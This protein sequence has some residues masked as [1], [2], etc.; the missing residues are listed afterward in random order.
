MPLGHPANVVLGAGKNANDRCINRWVFLRNLAAM[1]E[2]G[3]IGCN[4]DSRSKQTSEVKGW[5]KVP[6]EDNL[7]QK[8]L[9]AI[10]R[11][12]PYPKNRENFINCGLH[13]TEHCFKRDLKYEF[14]KRGKQKFILMDDVVPSV[15]KFSA[16]PRKRRSSESRAKTRKNKRIVQ[17]VMTA[18]APFL[19]SEDV[20]EHG[21]LQST[22][23]YTD[24]TPGPGTSRSYDE[25]YLFKSPTSSD[26]N[27]E[28][29]TGKGN[30]GD[31]FVDIISNK[32]VIVDIEKLKTLFVRCFNCGKSSTVTKVST[33]G[34]MVTFELEC[35]NE[36]CDL[37]TWNSQF[38][39]QRVC[40]GNL[41]L[42]AGIILSGSTFEP[43]RKIMQT[44]GVQFLGKSSFYKIQ[45]KFIFPA[46][47]HVYNE[48]RVKI[49]E[50]AKS[51]SVK[52]IGDGRFDSPGNSAT[53]GTYTLMNS[54]NNE[55][56]DFFIA[57]VRNAGNS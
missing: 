29:E 20:I 37:T 10:K 22:I 39:Q 27:E 6:T 17:G 18:S 44:A 15:F 9:V 8:W 52:L 14:T 30:V 13:F 32:Y 2:S 49:L 28:E 34:T 21:Q 33:K 45:E 54:E 25:E 19:P 53:F 16:Q 4:N 43:I 7:R 50:K 36:E 31:P 51:G 47:N 55:I 56:F 48:R 24:Q 57:H 38:T 42:S 3:A 1:V 41:A 12:P 40:E 35:E 5:H 11:D 46:I 26:T 23:I